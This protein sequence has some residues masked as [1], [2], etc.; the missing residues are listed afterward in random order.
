MS[1]IFFSRSDLSLSYLVFKTNQ[2]YLLLQLVYHTQFF[3]NIIFTASL[4]LLKSKGTGTNLSI[5]DFKFAKA[6]FTVS[7]DVLIPA[8]FFEFVFAA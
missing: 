4:N 3:N 5:S 7:L 1:L 8:A 2:F 6:D